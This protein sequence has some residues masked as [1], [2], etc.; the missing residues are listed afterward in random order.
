MNAVVAPKR[1]LSTFWPSTNKITRTQH[2]HKL[3]FH[4]SCHAQRV[5]VVATKVGQG[6]IRV[7]SKQLLLITSTLISRTF[8]KRSISCHHQWYLCLLHW[9]IQSSIHLSCPR[10]VNSHPDLHRTL[11][12]IT[13]TLIASTVTQRSISCHH[14]WYLF[15]LHLMI[16]LLI[17]L[18]CPQFVNS[19]PDLHR[20][21]RQSCKLLQYLVGLH[22]ICQI[23]QA[24]K[25]QYLWMHGWWV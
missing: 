17:H 25:L 1:W 18:R 5:L 16:Q 13:G 12:V 2:Y 8:T 10:F 7:G 3:I 23:H 21:Q 6:T 24:W 11:L 19:H 15:L 22:L 20:T 14:R 9:K 4:S